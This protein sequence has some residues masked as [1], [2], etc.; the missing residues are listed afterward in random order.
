MKKII[1]AIAVLISSYSFSQGNLQF[2]RVINQ[3]ILTDE[4]LQNYPYGQS[5]YTLV[6]P[7][8]KVVK[9]ESFSM[10]G[11]REAEDEIYNIGVNY[12]ANI[13]KY[14][15]TLGGHVIWTPQYSSSDNITSNIRFP[16]WFGEGSYFLEVRA[17][18]ARVKVSLS[19]IEFNIVQ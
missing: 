2:N 4:P 11:Y 17:S 1:I 5:I 10:L 7:A 8:G 14:W 6:V 16:I 13:E 12:G 19:A 15:A 18:I 3:L 9:V